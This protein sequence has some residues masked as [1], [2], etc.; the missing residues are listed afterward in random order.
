MPARYIGAR[1]ADFGEA[2]LVNPNSDG[3]YVTGAVGTGKTHLA[4]A[5]LRQLLP[6][7]LDLDQYDHVMGLAAKWESVPELLGRLRETFGGRGESETGVLCDYMLPSL[8]VLD[9]LGAE[10]STDWTGQA[11]YRL[12]SK[13]LNDLRQTIVTSNLSLEELNVRDPRLASRLGGMA[14]QRLEGGDRR[15]AVQE[16][17]H[18]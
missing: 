2:E 16:A 6:E 12:V 13:R 9:D 1:L 11:I 5:W 3:L 17:A 18:A 7:H 15:L 8:L 4:T 14:Y 10:Q